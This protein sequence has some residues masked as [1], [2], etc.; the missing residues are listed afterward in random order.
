[1]RTWYN[2][3]PEWG[4]MYCVFHIIK[5]VSVECYEQ[6][7][8]W[9]TLYRNWISYYWWPVNVGLIWSRCDLEERSIGWI[10]AFLRVKFYS[11]SFFPSSYAHHNTVHATQCKSSHAKVGREGG[12]GGCRTEFKRGGWGGRSVIAGKFMLV[13]RHHSNNDM[14]LKNIMFLF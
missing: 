13:V 8:F 10:G 14:E 3:I 5:C 12:V 6:G 9:C 7:H 2:F 11:F 4:L 1:M